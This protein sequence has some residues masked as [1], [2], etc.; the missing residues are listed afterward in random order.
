[1]LIVH[2]NL[3]SE[4]MLNVNNR[5]QWVIDQLLRLVK[6]AQFIKNEKCVEEIMQFFALHAFFRIEQSNAEI[7][8]P[9]VRLDVPP[10]GSLS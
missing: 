5:R 9:N 1:M 8:I 4:T 2:I 6:N 7:S 10:H 3:Y